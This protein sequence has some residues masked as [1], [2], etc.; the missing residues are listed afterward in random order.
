MVEKA[1]SSGAAGVR[2]RQ[3]SGE[4]P[5]RPGARRSSSCTRCATTPVP[6]ALGGGQRFFWLG[7]ALPGGCREPHP[8]NPGPSVDGKRQAPGLVVP[9]CSA[10]RETSR[11]RMSG[12]LLVVLPY[13]GRLIRAHILRIRRYRDTSG[14]ET[15][16]T[17]AAAAPARVRTPVVIIPMARIRVSFIEAARLPPLSHTHAS[18]PQPAAQLLRAEC[19]PSTPLRP[20]YEGV[21]TDAG[22][23]SN[24]PWW[25][26]V[27]RL[28]QP[29]DLP[30]V[31]RRAARGGSDRVGGAAR[32]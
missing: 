7:S 5:A 18:L 25:Q 11:R 30:M 17:T 13:T 20:G 3:T 16:T 15:A 29:L 31:S 1:A 12:E 26:Q 32:T 14:A 2:A 8:K 24:R 23:R 27:L 4:A 9:A 19:R 10:S 28:H 21:G 6:T 22:R